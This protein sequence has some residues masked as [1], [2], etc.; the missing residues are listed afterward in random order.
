MGAAVATTTAGYSAGVHA[1][2]AMKERALSAHDAS[3]ATGV[4]VEDVSRLQAVGMDT[5]AIAKFERALSQRS[6]GFADLGLSAEKLGGGSI[7]DA[8]G[9][10]A[11]AMQK[12]M[13]A[14]DRTRI[15]FELFG[16]SGYEVMPMLLE[17]KGKLKDLG[18]EEIVTAEKAAKAHKYELAKKEAGR[19]SEE[20]THGLARA[21]GMDEGFDTAWNRKKAEVLGLLRGGRQGAFEVQDK[22]ARHD[23]DA[24][25]FVEEDKARAVN[26]KMAESAKRAADAARQHAAHLKEMAT[27]AAAVAD[28]LNNASYQAGEERATS[29]TSCGRLTR[30]RSTQTP[31]S[32]AAASP[33]G[34][35]RQGNGIRPSWRRSSPRGEPTECS[36]RRK[37]RQ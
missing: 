6:G 30:A 36:N 22:F 5:T 33:A 27:N 32:T 16:K 31:R 19:Q 1:T 21:V 26:E 34:R 17:M 23:E 9:E 12:P 3:L 28:S 10:V 29:T 11:D 20:L 8:L 7:K 25:H 35:S 2:H 15:A 37:R 18:D 24:K 14:A 13:A 4:G